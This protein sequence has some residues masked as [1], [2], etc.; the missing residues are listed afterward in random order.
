MDL[1]EVYPR[2]CGATA[3]SDG[4]LRYAHGLSPRVRGYHLRRRGR[5]SGGRSI[6][7]GA[8]LPQRDLFGA[9]G[10]GVYPRGCGATPFSPGNIRLAVGLSPRVRGYRG[11]PMTDL[12]YL[13]SIPAGAG[14]P[15]R[16]D[17]RPHLSKVYPRGCGATG[18]A[19][20]M[21]P[22]SWGLSPRVRGYRR[23]V[24]AGA[25][26]AG[27]IPAGAGLPLLQFVRTRA[28]RARRSVYRAE[29][30]PVCR[31]RINAWRATAP[32]TAFEA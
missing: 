18:G 24:G 4:N 13:G 1:H 21:T 26:G 6:P 30:A 23:M 27:S 20:C 3:L 15:R 31:R 2:G 29:N 19:S 11:D 25:C 14:L 12:I 16:S 5:L 22:T 9:H 32:P 28:L 8:G 17:D 7:A 10:E